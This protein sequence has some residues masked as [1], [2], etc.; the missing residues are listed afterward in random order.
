MNTATTSDD[1]VTQLFQFFGIPGVT[2]NDRFS[3]ISRDG[4]VVIKV[5]QDGLTIYS[6]HQVD[7][8][9]TITPFTPEKMVKEERRYLISFLNDRGW[10]SSEIAELL[11][12]S[13][14][15]IY[16]ALKPLKSNIIEGSDEKD[17][18]C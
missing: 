8:E 17:I 3:I 14:A 15:T 10:K 2:T 7:N 4:F 6:A 16:N 9:N 11:N 12:V 5:S 13:I 1:P 18:T